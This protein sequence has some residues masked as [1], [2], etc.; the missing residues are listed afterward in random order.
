MTCTAA[1]AI[2]SLSSNILK[3]IICKTFSSRVWEVEM[4]IHSTSISS[5]TSVWSYLV[6]CSPEKAQAASR[7][8]PTQC[9]T[10]KTNFDNRSPQHISLP[11]DPDRLRMHSSTSWSRQTVNLHAFCRDEGVVLLYYCQ[12][13]SMHH[14]ICL[15]SVDIRIGPLSDRSNSSARSLLEDIAVLVDSCDCVSSIVS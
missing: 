7:F 6:V 2:F 8:I 9:T 4:V 11:A 14:F 15:L 13:L 3:Y 10:S 12:K 1:R 5:L